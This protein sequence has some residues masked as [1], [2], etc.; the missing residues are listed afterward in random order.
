M[1]ITTPFFGVPWREVYHYNNLPPGHHRLERLLAWHQL[2]FQGRYGALFYELLHH[3]GL[4]ERELFFAES[5]RELTN[6]SS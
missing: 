5:E 4:S 1:V 3:S 2:A 6:Y